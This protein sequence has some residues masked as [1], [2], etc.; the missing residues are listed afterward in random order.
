MAK[1]RR[2]KGA[3]PSITETSLYGPVKDFLIAQG[4]TVRAEVSACDI[5][6]TR[7][8]DLVI[9]ELKRN[10]ST[11]L[12]F[13]ATERQRITDSVY[14]ALPLP[15]D[16]FERSRWR[17]MKRLLRRLELGLILVSLGPP[18]RAEVVLHPGPYERRKPRKLRTALLEE[19]AGRSG[20]FNVG[21]S[22]RRKIVTAYRENAIHIACCLERF[23]P[24]SPKRLRAMGTGPKTLSI[25]S[26]NFYGWFHRVSRGVYDLTQKGREE[27]NRYPELA[28]YYRTEL[29]KMA[30][31]QRPLKGQGSG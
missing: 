16:G 18:P 11:E 21:G 5:V 29:E 23:G 13:Q 7:G 2:R 20:D 12:L 10:F 22:A 3:R 15:P 30:D 1:T 14:V 6:A 31:D 4:F 19:V 28:S 26:N 27:V 25:L 9:V 8:D 24:L 17:R